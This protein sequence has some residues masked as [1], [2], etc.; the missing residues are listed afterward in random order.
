MSGREHE[1][2]SDDAAAYMLGGLEPRGTE[3]EG[4]RRGLRAPPLEDPLVHGGGRNA[5]GIGRAAP[6]RPRR[7]AG[8]CWKRFATT[9]A[10][11]GRER[12]GDSTHPPLCPPGCAGPANAPFGWRPLAGLAASGARGGRLRRLRGRQRR[13]AAGSEPTGARSSPARRPEGDRQG[14]TQAAT[15]PRLRLANVQELP[16]RPRARGLGAARRRS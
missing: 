8:G 3:F 11:R 10:P 1:R 9:P 14:R 16:E 6:S 15:R 5:P 7:S 12:P 2:W 13:G 4:H